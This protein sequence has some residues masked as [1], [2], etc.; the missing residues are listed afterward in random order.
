VDSCQGELLFEACRR[1]ADPLS[2]P[3]NILSS[4]EERT[5]NLTRTAAATDLPGRLQTLLDALVF[6]AN[7][8]E[9]GATPP[10]LE[11]LLKHDVLANLVRLSLPDLPRGIKGEVI[12]LFSNLLVLL[13][14]RF[15][16]HNAV[17]KPLVRLL[18]SC[19]QP[20][21]GD[22]MGWRTA[23]PEYEE[24]LVDLMCHVCS[25][26]KS[27]PELIVIFFHDRTPRPSLQPSA[28]VV[29]PASPTGST[30]TLASSQA[31]HQRPEYEFLIFSYLL[32]FVHREG[33]TG[34]F[35]RAGLLFLVDVALS[36][37]HHRNGGKPTRGGIP[38]SLSAS[39]SSTAPS[40]DSTLA[41]AEYLLDSDFAQVLGAGLGAL[42]GLLPSKLVVRPPG[43]SGDAGDPEAGIEPTGMVLGGLGDLAQDETADSLG[44]QDEEARMRSLGLGVSN[45]PEFRA[46]LDLFLK[47]VEFTQ[48]VVRRSAS[49][50]PSADRVT[51]DAVVSP[52]SPN[53][54]S[55]SRSVSPSASSATYP[56][57]ALVASA[58]A[59][60]ILESV[61]S[62]FLENVV[63]PSI[64]E[65]SETDGSAVAV[66][67]YLDALLGV[68]DGE[69]RLADTIFRFLMAE[70]D[71]NDGL[72]G[73]RSRLQSSSST[74]PPEGKAKLRRRKSSALILIE[75]AGAKSR[76]ESSYFTSA[77]RFSLRDLVLQN[78]NSH[79]QPTA[80]AAL[81]LVVTLL[82]RHDRIA[83]ELLDFLHDPRATAFPI[84][85]PEVYED[86]GS[87]IARDSSDSGS[88]VFIYPV[89]GEDR[90]DESDDFTT[91]G[92]KRGLPP[93][94]PSRLP[95]RIPIRTPAQAIY[96]HASELHR[97]LS[98]V[99][100]ASGNKSS[101]T[102]EMMSTGYARYLD[103]AESAMAR[104][105]AF[106]RGLVESSSSASASNDMVHHRLDPTAPLLA[107]I[108][109][110]LSRFFEHSPELNLALTGAIASLATCPY[111]SLQGWL[112]GSHRTVPPRLQLEES[113]NDSRGD[114]DDAYDGSDDGDDR[115]FDF[116]MDAQ[117]IGDVS[118]D[119]A[120][121]IGDTEDGVVF[122]VI[123]E[124]AR[125]VD[126]YR[127]TIPGF[128][129]YLGE[130]RQGLTFAENLADALDFED[131]S[132]RVSPS[133]S[134]PDNKQGAASPPAMSASVMASRNAPSLDGSF[135]SRLSSS[136]STSRSRPPPQ[137]REMSSPPSTPGY[138][139]THL[140]VP[141]TP[142]TAGPASPFAAHYRQTGSIS[143]TPLV[144]RV[145]LT[146]SSGRDRADSGSGPDDTPLRR[147][148]ATLGT[149]VEDYDDDDDADSG[150]IS[151]RRGRRDST[152]AAATSVKEPTTAVSLSMILDNVVVLE[153]AVKELV[154]LV[155][156]RKS[157]GIDPIV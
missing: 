22:N 45:S 85:F 61:R 86:E 90:D 130:R 43:S 27:S 82:T 126:H 62:I 89:N 99:D 65:C 95:A 103:D 132:F 13:D 115:S 136:T 56:A 144:A 51:A 15:V 102:S 5:R 123:R 31:T 73:K 94:T 151:G 38:A 55:Y 74:S 46:A 111:R 129:R 40:P 18:R 50:S 79:N 36:E 124:L 16:V 28:G 91:P 128:D 58:I 96:E 64:L 142:R 21:D 7:R 39:T 69:G 34:D 93:R 57:I 37:G 6:E 8:S 120:K 141:S 68:V 150:S 133:D 66:L 20:E 1:R 35:A 121:T 122:G 59:S 135:I 33:R 116:S 108:I 107:S 2:P 53:P 97:L 24:D 157:L 49:S 155:Q 29:R 26:I 32:R 140:D 148:M 77:G 75:S 154:A 112:S 42:Y 92:D 147:K 105:P 117:G 78:I 87:A 11:Y 19:V 4:P 153:E 9:E 14:E 44:E 70:D 72:W 60:A 88:D 17:H 100:S 30:S 48:D 3:K 119:D 114:V 23:D 63:Y 125:Q 131:T 139:V 101:R 83:L 47:L 104:D 76:R 71:G 80:T 98:I 145:P 12:R 106:R 52:P 134:P 84:A 109:D 10:V 110:S 138:S 113:R 127:A 152:P 25:R 137:Q 54:L 81:K 41:L 149:L 146:P 143:V 67:S 156:V 118:I